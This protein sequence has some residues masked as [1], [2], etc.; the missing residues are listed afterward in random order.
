MAESLYIL[1]SICPFP[2]IH[3]P[4]SDPPFH[5]LVLNSNFIIIQVSDIIQC[6]F[7]CLAYFTSH[8]PPGSAMLS[9][10]GWF[11][12]YGW[13]TFLYTLYF[14]RYYIIFHCILYVIFYYHFVNTILAIVNNS[15]MHMG[16]QGFFFLRDRFHYFLDI[17]PDV[18][19]LDYMVL[20][21][22]IFGGIFIIPGHR[23]L[24]VL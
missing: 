8:C 11:H 4:G 19:L 22:L 21:F 12:S 18:E 10:M 20:L 13:I 1:T 2:F 15:A 9:L 23:L 7:P 24:E 3:S 14:I 6:V 5:S 17:Y 16:V